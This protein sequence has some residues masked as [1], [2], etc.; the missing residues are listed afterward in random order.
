MIKYKKTP[1]GY[2]MQKIVIKNCLARQVRFYKKDDREVPAELF[3]AKNQKP[4]LDGVLRA[5]P[6]KKSEY[7]CCVK[8]KNALW[9]G[10]GNGLTRYE[11]N[12]LRD[13]DR[14]MFFSAER[15]LP[16]NN[17]LA[18][19]SPDAEKEAVWALTDTGVSRIELISLSPE[20]KAEIL[21]EESKMYVDRHG[22]V[23][24][25]DLIIPRDPSS[26]VPYGHS[27]NSGTFTATYA[28]GEICK[29]AY[30]KRT[31]GKDSEKTK[32]AFLSAVRAT[33]ACLLLC[34]IPCR[35]DG[36][37]ARTYITKDE[38]VPNDGLFYRITGKKAV[39]LDLSEARK[40][41]VSGKVID[42]SAD[43]PKRLC[44]LFEDEGYT[45]DDITYKGD[46]SSDEITHHYLL[47]Y[48]AHIIL[49][50]DDPE[51][52]GFVKDRSKAILRHILSHGNTLCE[53][54]GLPT[55][56]AK[57]NE[58]YFSTPLGWS[59]GC[60]NAAELLMYHKVTMFVT[61][62]KGEWENSYNDLALSRGYANLTT[63][64]DMRF[65]LSAISGG[66]E[67]VEELMYGD[68]ALATC[69]YWLLITLEENE[70]L[71]EKYIRGDKGWNGTFRREHNPAYDI[72][73][74]LS[75]PDE[76]VNTEM[77]ADWFRR[78]NISRV[79]S[80]V[81]VDER[82]D[83]PK[84]IRLGGMEETS[85]LL[86]PDE[87]GITKYDR[88][89]FAYTRAFNHDGLKVLESCYVY[90]YAYWLGKYFGIIEDEEA[91]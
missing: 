17:V 89:P 24:Q 1:K 84:R 25:K 38:P 22:M 40:R 65:H 6:S 57:W 4:E 9:I 2:K 88:D 21:T 54:D 18:L 30:C 34:Y 33:E 77:L 14:V 28:V 56:W 59:D 5:L 41:G 29:Y 3:E 91:Q 42:A 13:A 90:T 43:I 23:S 71:K 7:T 74:M 45:L 52:D 11:E 73:Y 85:W 8:T 39:C 76:E 47:F 48:F 66:L 50:E 37:V 16:D 49:G 55:T 35:G 44:H 60:L 31:L 58:E 79:C 36:F 63:L 70:E 64:H 61:G 78:G 51:L 86:M 75:C 46:T 19:Y 68:N 10:A 69:A 82:K 81:S 53:C 26:A 27:D 87:R 12:A 72:P 80:A 15:E 83:V 20:R 32:A 67:Q 62:E